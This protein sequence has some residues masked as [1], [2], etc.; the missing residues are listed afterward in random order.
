MKNV[1]KAHLDGLEEQI[2]G[3]ESQKN[4]IELL[5]ELDVLC[6]HIEEEIQAIDAPHE[7]DEFTRGMT[8]ELPDA[9]WKLSK[10]RQQLGAHSVQ[11]REKY[12]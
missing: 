11:L 3:L 10:C 5:R 8:T 6:G 12:L 2:K 1:S 9:R 4:A 7:L